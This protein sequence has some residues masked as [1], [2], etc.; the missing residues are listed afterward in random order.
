M[1]TKIIPVVCPNCGGQIHLEEGPKQF[2]CTYC[3]TQ[4]MLDTNEKRFS[5]TKHVINEAKMIEA[6][7]RSKAMVIDA[8]ER[9]RVERM[10]ARNDRIRAR[11]DYQARQMDYAIRCMKWLVIMILVSM[12]SMFVFSFATKS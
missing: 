7:G 5:F 11:S 8:K 3:G 9:A 2:F 4:L 6:E 1:A 12:L 10:R